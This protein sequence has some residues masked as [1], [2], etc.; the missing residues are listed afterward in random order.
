MSADTATRFA[1]LARDLAPSLLDV[2]PDGPAEERLESLA[3]VL[4]ELLKSLF[5]LDA[6][7][8]RYRLVRSLEE[9]LRSALA[10][11]FEQ[12]ATEAWSDG[13]LVD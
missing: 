9:R 2:V 6:R 13:T 12:A 10:E 5:A 11:V 7:A 4:A 3:R 1:S 8:H